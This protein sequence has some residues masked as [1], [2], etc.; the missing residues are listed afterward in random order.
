MLIRGKPRL[1]AMQHV[2]ELQPCLVCTFLLLGLEGDGAADP[3]AHGFILPHPIV[4]SSLLL[5]M[6]GLFI[7]AHAFGVLGAIPC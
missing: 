4:G 6:H 1:L 2:A 5:P 7:S 3:L